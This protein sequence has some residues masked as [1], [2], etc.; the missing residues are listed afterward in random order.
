MME[1]INIEKEISSIFDSVDLINKLNLIDDKSQEDIDCLTRN[2]EHLK[3]KMNQVEFV[4]ILNENQIKIIT[5][6]I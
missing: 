4:E 2:V 3:I 5:S 6:L 1:E